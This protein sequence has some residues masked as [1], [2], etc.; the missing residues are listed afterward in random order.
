MAA[1]LLVNAGACSSPFG[2]DPD[3]YARQVALSRL[4]EIKT[5]RLAEHE[6]ARMVAV[7]TAPDGTDRTGGSM[8]AIVAEAAQDPK[9]PDER[10]AAVAPVAP[11]SLEDSRASALAHNLDLRVAVI[12]PAIAR[13]SVNAEEA[14][15]EK[16][17]TL[18]ASWRELDAPTA[19]D[20]NSSSLSQQAIEP[21]VRIPLRTGG[22]AS[23]GLPIVRSENNNSFSTLNP[24]YS[25]DLEF[26]ISQPLL[27]G[28]GRRVATGALRIAGY[29]AQASEA[30]TKLEVIRQIA[31][32]DRAYW[33]LFEARQVLD[34]AQQQLELA[35]A[36]RDRAKRQVD[37]E[38]LPEVEQLRAESGVADRL[39]AILQAK[40]DVLQRQ[41][42]LK[43]LIN[44]PEL[45]VDGKEMILPTSPPDP[46]EYAFDAR[47]LVAQALDERME[48]LELEL[49]IA[50][51]AVRVLL[52][53]DATLPLLTLDYTYRVNGLGRSV[54]RSLDTLSD[55]D[56]EDWELGLVAEVP[57]GNEQ[58][59]SR[60]RA[61]L[62][63]RLQRLQTR[64]ARAQSIQ[65]E[66]LNAIDAL[67]AA[68]QRILAAR[69]SV[70]LNTRTYQAEQRQFG[71]GRTTSTD[72][73]DAAARLAEAQLAEVRALTDYQ[74]SQVDLAFATGTLLGAAKVEWAPVDAPDVDLDPAHRGLERL[75]P[76]E[77]ADP[78][79]RA[80][81]TPARADEASVP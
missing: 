60:L 78:G 65:T 55:N 45:P 7:A 21:G 67:D 23:I 4:R 76:R 52:D 15:F 37:A 51:D 56:F 48:M 44:L 29:E 75:F 25:S 69:Q 62:L 54:N 38:V 46:V 14:A 42:E 68:W 32:V 50:A 8:E 47:A 74:V 28:A 24:A 80:L 12:D 81:P 5:A 26:S 31:A 71:V 34:V 35:Q 63:Q 79:A 72:V 20:L 49:A 77:P 57:I 13:E 53:R 66:V 22:T 36:Q 59:R 27:R 2:S 10:A 70:I 64:E 18:N 17:F 11:L 58:A 16:I 3:D 19:S 40:A 73:L 39:D 1:V 43:R 9:T 33:R 6:A 61:S 41:R 30:R